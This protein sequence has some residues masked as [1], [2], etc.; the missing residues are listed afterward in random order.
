MA[1]RRRILIVLVILGIFHA[2]VL[3]AGILAPYGYADQHR[4]Y[5]YTPPMKVHFSAGRLVV[6]AM[7]PGGVGYREDPARQFPVRFFVN[8]RLFGVDSPGVLFL[9]GTDGYGRDVFSR[10][11]YGAQ[12]SL[13]TGVLAAMLSLAIGW[14]LGTIAGFF[15]GWLD[16][17]LMRVSELF[18]ALPWLYFLL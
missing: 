14:L 17:F 4:D 10:V 13:L 15:G 2:M 9:L 12:V 1:K 11:L 16:Q 8:G 6:S 5:P 7:V 18:M 3:A